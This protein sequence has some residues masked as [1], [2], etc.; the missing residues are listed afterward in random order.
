MNSRGVR[1]SAAGA[2]R[3]GRVSFS[4]NSA[5]S[6]DRRYSMEGVVRTRPLHT[7]EFSSQSHA[8]GRSLSLGSSRRRDNR[9]TFNSSL[10]HTVEN[11]H[12]T[13]LKEKR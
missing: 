11:L 10:T 2:M 7:I 5:G 1:M 9:E 12:L 8:I 13:Y 6:I 3:R 4:L